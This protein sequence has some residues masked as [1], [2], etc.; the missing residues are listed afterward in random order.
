M[1]AAGGHLLWQVHT[2]KIDDP[3][4]CLTLFRANRDSGA[5]IAA[6]FL[7]SSWIW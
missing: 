7:L 6:A 5:L 3:A 1:F 2:L 4:R